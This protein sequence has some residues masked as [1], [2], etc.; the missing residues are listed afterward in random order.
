MSLPW[1]DSTN[2]YFCH[3]NV[4]VLNKI[5]QAKMSHTCKQVAKFKAASTHT[6]YYQLLIALPKLTKKQFSWKEELKVALNLLKISKE[7]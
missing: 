3:I 1:M 4:A 6:Q 7:F 2:I 5:C